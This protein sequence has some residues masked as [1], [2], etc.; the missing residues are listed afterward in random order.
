MGELWHVLC[1]DWGENWL[2]YNNTALHFIWWHCCD[3]LCRILAQRDPLP[4]S[5]YLS[6]LPW[7]FPGAPLKFNGAPGNIQGNLTALFHPIPFWAHNQL[8][9]QSLVSPFCEH[10]PEIG[11]CMHLYIFLTQMWSEKGNKWV[12]YQMCLWFLIFKWRQPVGLYTYPI[13][14]VSGC[15]ILS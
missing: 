5:T 15:L 7:I 10:D 11:F 1:E 8:M 12:K 2:R 9:K 6:R 3:S 13:N 14:L 4:R